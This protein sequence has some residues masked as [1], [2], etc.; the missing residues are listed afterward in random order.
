MYLLLAITCGPQPAVRES[1]YNLVDGVYMDEVTYRCIKGYWFSKG[2]TN[3][4]MSCDAHGVWVPSIASCIG[5]ISNRQRDY[6]ITPKL[7]T[8]NDI[9]RSKGVC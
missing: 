7:H 9:Q 5:I 8:K 1:M 6:N 2:V 4:T 3:A